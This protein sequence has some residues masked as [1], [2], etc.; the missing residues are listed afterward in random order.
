M[1][2]CNESTT[3]PLFEI[4]ATFAVARK[5]ELFPRNE[6]SAEKPGI[7]VAFIAIA[8]SISVGISTYRHQSNSMI[9]AQI[10]HVQQYHPTK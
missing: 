9:H 7:V 5:R 4:A 8:R 10:K 1:G 6:A 2:I 3:S